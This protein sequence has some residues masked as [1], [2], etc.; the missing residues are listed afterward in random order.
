M[1]SGETTISFTV[2]LAVHLQALIIQWIHY[3]FDT[4][5]WEPTTNQEQDQLFLTNSNRKN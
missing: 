1:I 5:Q 3:K 4:I 2:N